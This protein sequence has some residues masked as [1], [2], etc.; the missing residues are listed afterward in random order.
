MT[1]RHRDR[2]LSPESVHDDSPALPM[3][4]SGI[5]GPEILWR[6]QR[7]EDSPA[8]DLQ[9]HFLLP[10]Q[11]IVHLVLPLHT[12]GSFSCSDDEARS[13]GSG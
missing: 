2:G 7:T 10:S 1:R 8:K 3:A 9:I 6:K 5:K 11:F 12:N 4:S 13:V